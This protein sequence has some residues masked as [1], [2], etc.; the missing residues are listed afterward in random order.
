MVAPSQGLAVQESDTGSA[1]RSSWEVTW[2]TGWND[3]RLS[4]FSSVPTATARTVKKPHRSE[5]PLLHGRSRR[6][7]VRAGPRGRRWRAMGCPI[8]RGRSRSL[9][10][11]HGVRL[12]VWRGHYTHSHEGSRSA[13]GNAKKEMTSQNGSLTQALDRDLDNDGAQLEIVSNRPATR[14]RR[15]DVDRGAPAGE[16]LPVA[17]RSR[18]SL[19]VSV[20]GP[21]ASFGSI[22]ERSYDR[23]QR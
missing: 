21:N 18:A 9:L 17:G 7:R 22:S 5:Q 13:S 19:Y 20:P 16:S 23:I 15:P 11:V 1:L 8:L 4:C 2:R 6:V 10:F 12:P 14:R 3:A